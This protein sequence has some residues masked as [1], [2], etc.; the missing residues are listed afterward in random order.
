[1][2]LFNNW[3]FDSLKVTDLMLHFRVATKN[4]YGLSYSLRQISERTKG[5]SSWGW[6]YVRRKKRGKVCKVFLDHRQG[7][8][9]E[10]VV[11][12]IWYLL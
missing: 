4:S 12:Q 7:H 1:M 11:S 2:L 3:L 5:L 10:Q 8:N 6:L 9:H